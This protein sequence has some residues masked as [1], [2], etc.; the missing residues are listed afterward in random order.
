[1]ADP[2]QSL[3]TWSIANTD[4][5]G[6]Q[7][8]SAPRAALHPSDHESS[9][10]EVQ[11]APSTEG[12]VATPQPKKKIDTGVLDHIMGKSDAVMMREKLEFAMDEAQSVNDRVF[13]LDDFE[14]VSTPGRHSK[15]CSW[16]LIF[17]YR[18][19]QRHLVD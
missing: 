17:C 10:P 8:S 5:S 15:A 9:G 7:R 3:L 14:M 13:A 12:P 6:Q 18:L 1:M 19:P 4:T 2:L 11:L 16:K